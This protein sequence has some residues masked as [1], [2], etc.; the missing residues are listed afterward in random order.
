[1]KAYKKIKLSVEDAKVLASN[2]QYAID[3]S[4]CHQVPMSAVDHGSEISITVSPFYKSWLDATIE[5]VSPK[6]SRL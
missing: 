6:A 1:M 4:E 2:L 5:D 3:E